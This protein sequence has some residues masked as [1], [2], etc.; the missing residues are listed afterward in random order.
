MPFFGNFS[1]R[2][3]MAIGHA[4]L[5][6][7]SKMHQSIWKILFVLGAHEYLKRL[8]G[9]IRKYLFFYLKMF[10]NNSVSLLFLLLICRKPQ[11]ILSFRRHNFTPNEIF[12]GRLV[13][14]EVYLSFLHLNISI[15]RY[16]WRLEFPTESNL[17]AQYII[18]IY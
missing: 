15:Q 8:E 3:G 13:K 2:A 18:Y 10:W 1:E 5:V 14:T 16:D 11:N 17:E 9:K 7:P 12:L 6:W 4:L